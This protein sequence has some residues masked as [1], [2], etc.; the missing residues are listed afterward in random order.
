MARLPALPPWL[1]RGLEAGVF[2]ALLAG[3]TLL[4]FTIGEGAA[5]PALP[6]GIAASLLLA[7]PVLS[8]GV[9]AVAYPILLAATRSDALLGS[10]TGLL[11]AGDLVTL[12]VTG[13]VLVGSIDRQVPLG[14][15]VTLLSMPAAIAGILAGEFG[16]PL[17]FGL[18]AGIR[19]AVV[20][21]I[22]AV[23]VVILAAR[24]G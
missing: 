3:G 15:L 24:L 16:S 2:S 8:I 9:M 5:P 17:G 13:R 19:A 6:S 22:A 11:I 18:R 12:A 23:I 7:L 14:L 20:A 21:A 10:V 4:G 1:R